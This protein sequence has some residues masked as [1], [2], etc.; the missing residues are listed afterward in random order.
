MADRVRIERLDHVTVNVTDPERSRTYYT[1][2]LGLAEIPRP[3]TFTFP[4]CWF[5]L[6]PGPVLLHLV[7]QEHPDPRTGRH[8]AVWSADVH[9]AAQVL[10]TAGRSVRWDRTKI[11]G[12]DRFF[13]ED[14]DGNL[15]EVQGKERNGS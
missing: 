13:T 9:E 15:I 5:Q 7:K 12:I 1:A 8:L 6:G 3:A 14:P 10:E 11:P 4:G 2:L